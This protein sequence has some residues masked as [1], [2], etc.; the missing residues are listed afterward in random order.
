MLNDKKIIVVIPAGRKKTLEILLRYINKE[1]EIIDEIRFWLNTQNKDDIDY[2][3][4]YVKNNDKCT[5]DYSAVNDTNLGNSRCISLFFKNCIDEDAVYIRFD[6]DIVFME[7]DYIR[8]LVK[9]RI[10]NQNYFLVLGNIINNSVCDYTHKKNNALK[11][12]LNFNEDAT[13]QFGW[14]SS[15]LAVEKHESFFQNYKDNNLKLYVMENK[16]WSNRFSINIICWLGL[17]FKKFNGNVMYG[18]EEIWLTNNRQN[19]IFGEKVACHYS[20][21]IQKELIDST[22]ILENYKSL[23]K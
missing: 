8:E 20:F 13:C 11:T 2:I 22:N 18:D 14:G 10:N 17:E 3:E 16:P 5:I 1:I 15:E 19:V 21:W 6:D 4:N 9:F 12:K 7:N 23:L